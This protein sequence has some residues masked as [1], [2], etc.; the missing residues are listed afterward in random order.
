MSKSEIAKMTVAVV[1]GLL[2]SYFWTAGLEKMAIF[3]LA[4]MLFQIFFV[5]AEKKN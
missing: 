3:I 4:T 1:L 2:T 5:T